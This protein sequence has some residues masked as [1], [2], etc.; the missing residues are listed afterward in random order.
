MLRRVFAVPDLYQRSCNDPYHIIKKSCTG[1][2][3]RDQA[4]LFF[5]ERSVIVRT[6]VSV[7]V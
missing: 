7:C 5:T 3:D 2:P 6:V 1:H 4:A